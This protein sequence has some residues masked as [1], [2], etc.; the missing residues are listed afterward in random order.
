MK[1]E[2]FFLFLLISYFIIASA[3]NWGTKYKYIGLNKDKEDKLALRANSGE[4]KCRYIL[5]DLFNLS[6]K[7]SRPN[8]LKNPET[9]RNLELDCYNPH[10]ITAM[11]SNGL[12]FEIDGAQHY[13]YV[14]QWHGSEDG[15]E[16]QKM[17]DK[18]KEVLCIKHGVLLIRIPFSVQDKRKYILDKLYENNLSHYLYH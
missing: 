10:I 16:K 7:R 1:R 15:F 18:L 12:A 9:G 8:F 2:L 17:R 6:F 3:S 11:G 5:E 14:P 4:E 13:G